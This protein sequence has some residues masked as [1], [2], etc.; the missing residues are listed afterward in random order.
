LT[1]PGHKPAGCTGGPTPFGWLQTLRESL[2]LI[3]S[4][5]LSLAACAETLAKPSLT[6][7]A[8]TPAA[9]ILASATEPATDPLATEPPA[10]V[11][12]P[13]SARAESPWPAFLRELDFGIPAG[14]SH[15]PRALAVHS[16]LGRLYARTHAQ[17]LDTL[18]QVVAADCMSPSTLL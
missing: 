8:T 18:G 15:S 3:I 16:G 4:L 17:D 10:T 6:V 14:N 7:P 12:A 13:T 2:S 9:A 5:V 1:L 11:T